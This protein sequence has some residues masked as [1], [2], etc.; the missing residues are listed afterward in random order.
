MLAWA[1]PVLASDALVLGSYEDN[2][3]RAS[4]SPVALKTALGEEFDPCS[5]V[6]Y[7]KWRVGLSQAISLGN[8]WDI[9]P[10]Y[11]EPKESGMIITYDGKGHI[12]YYEKDGEWWDGYESN[13]EK[14]Q[15]SIRRLPIS[16]PSIRGYR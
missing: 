7:Y 13:F 3:V 1:W 2:F 6:S 5:C 12:A 10:W 9:M 8:A 14:C 15:T 16:D 4:N 11:L